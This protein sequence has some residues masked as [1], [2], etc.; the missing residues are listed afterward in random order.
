MIG[1]SKGDFPSGKFEVLA[2][3]RNLPITPQGYCTTFTV[4]LL[5][6][7]RG[8]GC[9]IG[10]RKQA[11]IDAPDSWARGD[12]FAFFHIRKRDWDA[13]KSSLSEGL[14]RGLMRGFR[15][16]LGRVDDGKEGCPYKGHGL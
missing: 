14:N 3:L 1:G 6:V 5:G 9:S 16:E 12:F 13:E 7:M 10:G 8:R 11:G 2:L 15:A 4:V